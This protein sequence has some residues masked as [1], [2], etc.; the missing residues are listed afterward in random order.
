MFLAAGSIP[1]CHIS[2]GKPG[3]LLGSVFFWATFREQVK[4]KRKR[5]LAQM[6]FHWRSD[7]WVATLAQ[8]DKKLIYRAE[9]CPTLLTTGKA[10]ATRCPSCPA[11]QQKCCWDRSKTALCIKYGMCWILT[12]L[13]SAYLRVRES[14]FAWSSITGSQHCSVLPRKYGHLQGQTA[15]VHLGQNLPKRANGGRTPMLAAVSEAHGEPE[16]RL[17]HFSKM[18]DPAEGWI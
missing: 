13:Q 2:I 8:L 15:M 1:R 17:G 11:A 5:S 12:S 9:E 6:K 16:L 10:T 7:S 18:C 3:L 4:R 14:L